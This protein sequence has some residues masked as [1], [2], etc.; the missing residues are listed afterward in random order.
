V[1]NVINGAATAAERLGYL[2]PNI[3]RIGP[4]V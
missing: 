2:E 3:S 4:S 1:G